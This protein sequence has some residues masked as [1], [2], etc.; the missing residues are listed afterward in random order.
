MPISK[1]RLARGSRKHI[2]VWR[3]TG[4]SSYECMR[5]DVIRVYDVMKREFVYGSKRK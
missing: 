5:C 1:S 3:V 4:V 2:H